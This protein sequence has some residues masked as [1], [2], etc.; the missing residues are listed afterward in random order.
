MYNSHTSKLS[1]NV[2]LGCNFLGL[3]GSP[4]KLDADYIER[5]LGNLSPVQESQLILLRQWLQ[6]THKGKVYS[7][8]IILCSKPVP[9]NPYTFMKQ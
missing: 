8:L 1:C 5:F 2:F 6:K 9:A 3:P 4:E 7:F